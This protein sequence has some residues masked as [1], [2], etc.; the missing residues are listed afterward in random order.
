MALLEWIVPRLRKRNIRRAFHNVVILARYESLRQA[1]PPRTAVLWETLSGVA[2]GV[3]QQLFVDNPNPGMDWGLKQYRRRLTSPLVG[4]IFWWMILYLFVVFR[5]RGL[6]G[7]KTQ[8]EFDALR[9]TAHRFIEW[10]CSQPEI[11]RDIPPL[12]D[13]SWEQQNEIGATMKLYDA[14][15]TALDVPIEPEKRAVQVARFSAQTPLLYSMIQSIVS[16]RNVAI[17]PKHE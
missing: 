17:N 4:Q 6:E 2:G 16:K 11:R 5:E 1:L 7:Y 8:E 9:D 10:L 3:L 15:L 14:V 13:E 12:W